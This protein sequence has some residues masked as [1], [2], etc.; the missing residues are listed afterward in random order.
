MKN[1]KEINFIL[2]EKKKTQSKI[3]KDLV[4]NF[5]LQNKKIEDQEKKISELEIKVK[6]LENE[7]KK[8]KSELKEILKK[9]IIDELKNEKV[10]EIEKDEE[11]N[12]I[13]N[14]KSKIIN[15][16]LFKQ[17]NKWIN[18]FKSLKFE[19]IFTASI[20]GDDSKIFHEKCDGKGPTVTIIKG[21]NGHIF[22]GYVTIPFSSDKKSHYDDKAFLFSLTNMKKFPIKI[23]EQ[24]V[25]H[26]PN[27]GPY[28]G[29]KDNCDLAI[30]SGCLSNNFSYCRP[31]S[32]E[33]NRVDL[34]GTIDE[35]FSVNDYEVFL[36][37]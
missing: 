20:N 12:P 36:I 25:C 9:E 28:I 1:I 13:I 33:F 5:N 27:W 34:I 10:I 4:L 24:A 35:R 31:N 19:L 7:N 17:L 26:Y 21:K 16:H 23:K 8:I 30:H 15:N 6:D 29:Y 14:Y 22:G 2:K 11:I 3:I 37:N 32:Y 18:P